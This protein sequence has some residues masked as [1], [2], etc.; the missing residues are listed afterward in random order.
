MPELRSLTVVYEK[1]QIL[2]LSYGVEIA[3]TYIIQDGG[4]A[5]IIDACS[6]HVA[7]E[8]KRRGI[9]PDYLILTHEHCDHLWGVNAVR[10]A[11]PNV[12]VIAQKYCSEAIGD[13]NRNKAKQYHIY[14]TLRFGEEYQN[15]EA[16]N[17]KYACASAEN[18]FEDKLEMTW[19]GFEIEL[20][21]APGHSPGSILIKI[22]GIGV[23]SGD[24]ILHE[25]VFL[26]FDGGDES[27]FKSITFPM[28]ENIPDETVIFPGHGEV[29]QM[30]EWRENGR[31][32]EK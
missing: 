27:A 26:K 28:I 10:G 17:R 19:H 5:V 18:V 12:Q 6:E 20:Y 1:P 31:T 24:S 4:H 23:F 22:E 13:P 3:N 25:K 14:S 7:K 9:T 29:F 2:Q 21:Y 15:E 8:L 30:R 16:K 32:T 11:F